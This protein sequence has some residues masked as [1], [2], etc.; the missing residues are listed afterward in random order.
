MEHDILSR[1]L[2]VEKEIQE[3]L[4]EEKARSLE[5]IEKLRREAEEE[6]ARE[7]E[8]IKGWCR[9]ALGE[10]RL[11]AERE[12]AELVR[13]SALQSGRLAALGD[14]V[15]SGIVLNYVRRIV[16]A[17]HAAGPDPEEASG[18]AP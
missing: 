5:R 9:E 12:A 13:N 14:E 17:E 4:R 10:A 8:R 7:E 15:L 6:I 1:V 16:S 11:A 18:P 2:E 3:K